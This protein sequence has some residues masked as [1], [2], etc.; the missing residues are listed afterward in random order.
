MWA[1]ELACVCV[2]PQSAC[3]VDGVLGF[4]LV[5]LMLTHHVRGELT[6]LG[7][8][9]FV[10]Q[11]GEGWPVPSFLLAQSLVEARSRDHAQC[12]SS[13]HRS[14]TETLQGKGWRV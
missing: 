13:Q 10:S 5:L 9:R 4:N 3:D 8:S 11:A 2:S 14:A 7:S 12:H 1:G 6:S